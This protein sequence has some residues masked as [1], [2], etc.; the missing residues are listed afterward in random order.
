MGFLE[1]RAEQ[2]RLSADGPARP[3]DRYGHK[4][5]A[6]NQRLQRSAARPPPRPGA[7]DDAAPS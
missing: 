1:R 6:R 4:P 5:A 2:F 7:G 3:L